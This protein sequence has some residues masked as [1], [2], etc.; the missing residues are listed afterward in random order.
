MRQ[1]ATV[2]A[3]V[4]LLLPVPAFTQGTF[5]LAYEFPSRQYDGILTTPTVTIPTTMQGEVLVEAVIPTA[6]YENPLN[7]IYASL[8]MSD[9]TTPSGW[10]LRATNRPGGWVGGPFID[11]DGVINP[12][13]ILFS[14][15]ITPTEQGKQFRA[16]FDL[17]RRMRVGLRVYRLER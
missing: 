11:D 17:P 4:L 3:L 15:S 2:I 9:L 8:Y 1:M 7:R 5:V 13:P 16:E 12:S 10:R 14:L 6:D